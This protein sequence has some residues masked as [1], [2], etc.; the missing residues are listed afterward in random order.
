[1]EMRCPYCSGEMKPYTVTPFHQGGQAK[2]IR[3]VRCVSCQHVSIE[4]I[5]VMDTM[6]EQPIVVRSSFL[7]ARAGVELAEVS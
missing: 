5:Q 1:M 3:W 4:R 2:L 6:P 7:P